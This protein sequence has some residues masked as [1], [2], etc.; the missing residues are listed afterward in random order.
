MK[1]IIVATVVASTIAFGSVTVITLAYNNNFFD[2]VKG[3]SNQF[4]KDK[5]LWMY[6]YEGLKTFD[7][8]LVIKFDGESGIIDLQGNQIN[9][10]NYYRILGKQGFSI[11]GYEG[12]DHLPEEEMVKR[13]ISAFRVK[14]AG[15]TQVEINQEIME[16][17]SQIS[18]YREAH[19]LGINFEDKSSEQ[20]LAEI[21]EI[22]KKRTF[23]IYDEYYTAE[24]Y[25]STLRMAEKNGIE[26]DGKTLR[27]IEQELLKYLPSI[28]SL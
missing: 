15:K 16:G 2:R 9:K 3:V 28:K 20:L 22:R 17:K 23:E 7:G 13:R 26:T 25:K 18:L 6:D 10:D 19:K 27:Q 24:D 21:M 4:S 12:D 1:K 8:K 11:I 5:S 14:T